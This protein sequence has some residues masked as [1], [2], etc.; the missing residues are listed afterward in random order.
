MHWRGRYIKGT[1]LETREAPFS[2]L[3]PSLDI[4]TPMWTSA[5]PILSTYLAKS[6]PSRPLPPLNSPVVLP[7]PSSM[8][9]ARAYPKWC[10]KCGNV[11][12]VQT[13]ASTTPKCHLSRGEEKITKH[14]SLTEP[15]Q[16]AGSSHLVWLQALPTNESF[17]RD[18][19]EVSCTLVLLHLWQMPVWLHSSGPRL[20]H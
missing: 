20:A 10:H 8:P 6:L 5:V 12:A 13:G 2:P 4:G 19:R 17:S 16:W 18:N 11:Q 15:Q 14:T 3:S 7:V 1:L 9:L